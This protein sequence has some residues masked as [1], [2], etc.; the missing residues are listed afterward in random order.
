VL[1][2]VAAA[3]GVGYGVLHGDGKHG[4]K[5]AT[6]PWT[7]PSPTATKAFGARSGGSHYGS[8]KLLLLPVPSGYTPGPDADGYGNDVALNAEQAQA[9]VKGESGG[10]S[11]KERKELAESIA[12]LHIESAGLRTYS[13]VGGGL[14]IRME[15]VQMKNEEA[16]RA[17]PDYFAALTKAMGVFRTGPKVKGYPK[18]VCVL[19]PADPHGSL[20]SMTCEATEGDLMVVMTADGTKPLRKTEAADVL[21]KQL[22]RIKDPGEAV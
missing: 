9:M 20:D 13:Q 2:A 12:A 6:T 7:A 18:A 4:A 8:P 21:R 19:A 22:D 17:E 5:A 11:A 3:G 15:I 10:G 14:V 1:V 16:A